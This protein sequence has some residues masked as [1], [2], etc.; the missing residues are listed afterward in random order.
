MYK[1]SLMNLL[2]AADSYVCKERVIWQQMAL[3]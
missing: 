2:I 3:Q 1:K